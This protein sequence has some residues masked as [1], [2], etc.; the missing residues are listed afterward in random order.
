MATDHEK[1][2]MLDRAYALDVARKL[3]LEVAKHLTTLETRDLE[4]EREQAT[5]DKLTSARK[6]WREAQSIVAQLVTEPILPE[7]SHEGPLFDRG[8]KSVAH[9]VAAELNKAGI[10]AEARG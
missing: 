1:L 9:A 7:R 3:A 10:L 5:R 6:A 2:A 4:V 8:Q